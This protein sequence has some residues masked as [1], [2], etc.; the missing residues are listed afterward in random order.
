[1]LLEP[2]LDARALFNVVVDALAAHVIVDT[3]TAE[4]YDAT[5]VR[6]AVDLSEGLTSPPALLLLPRPPP[7]PLPSR[8]NWTRL[9][10]SS[11]TNWTR[12][13]PNMS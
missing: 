2:S 13:V 7:P 11:R 3:R 9:V 10:P 6:G 8:T 4:A 5:H 1:M 12:L